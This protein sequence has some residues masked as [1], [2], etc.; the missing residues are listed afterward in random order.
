MVDKHNL[1]GCLF[2]AL[3]KVNLLYFYNSSRKREM[4]H[5]RN[6]LHV[7]EKL[8]SVAWNCSLGLRNTVSLTSA[9]TVEA[10]GISDNTMKEIRNPKA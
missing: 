5:G 1:L 7:R 4:V 2:K 6:C 8:L 3:L 10:D 9:I